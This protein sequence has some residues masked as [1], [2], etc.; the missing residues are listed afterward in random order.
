MLVRLDRVY[1]AL[2]IEPPKLVF[3][4]LAMLPDLAR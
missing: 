4:V 2:M 3:E 1:E